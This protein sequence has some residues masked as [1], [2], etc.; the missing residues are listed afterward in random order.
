MSN[1]FI[2]RFK[3]L[4][5][6]FPSL[7]L[8]YR[9]VRDNLEA[10]K[11][12]PTVTPYGFKFMGNTSM[13]NGTFEPMEIEV[14][15]KHLENADTFID[16]GANIGFYTCL[17]L[18]LNKYTIAFEPL[19]Y[20][21]RCL[22]RNLMENGWH[23]TEVFPLALSNRVGIASFYGSNTGASL[24]SGWASSSPL[25]KRTI[26]LSTLDTVLNK[27]LT[28]QQLVIKIDVEGSEQSVLEGAKKH[29]QFT[30]RPTWIVE[31][32]LTEHHP[33]GLNLNFIKTF[34]TF[35]QNGYEA[36]T[37]DQNSK[38]VTIADVKRWFV[39]RHRNFGT[40]NYLFTAKA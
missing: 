16:I 22:Y 28:G 36:R 10:T 3:P 34:E 19:E 23:K 8:S 27:R 5:Q 14:L 11:Q 38:A 25:L 29:L 40:H 15:Q 4:I 39:N 13:Q 6:R 31:I 30:P 35:W 17:A 2:K 7:E 26:P 21:L 24:I 37:V 32:N 1:L 12:K 20:N 18:S 9:T 33:A